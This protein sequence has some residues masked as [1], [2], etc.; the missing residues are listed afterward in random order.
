MKRIGVLLLVLLLCGSLFACAEL[1][2][3]QDAFFKSPES[4]MIGCTF[5]EVEAAFGPFSM[6]HI[7][8]DRPASYLFG[9]TN[10]A[11]HFD[12]P[13][14]QAAWAAQLPQGIGFIPGAVA[15]RSIQPADR[16]IGVSG[17]IRDFGIA[18]SDV[19]EISRY[20]SVLK[21]ASYET[22]DNTIYTL[23]SQDGAY[24]VFLYCTKGE[25]SFTANHQ[26]R[27]MAAGAEPQPVVEPVVSVQVTEFSLGGIAI[28]VGAVEAE[29]RGASNAHRTVTEQE[30]ADLV[31][32]CPD[33][34]KLVLDYCDIEGADQIGQLTELTD[35]Q[36]STCGMKDVSFVENLRNLT[37]LSICHN[38]LTDVSA[39]EDLQLTY[40][41]LGDNPKLGNRGVRSAAK[42]TTLKTLHL[43]EMNISSLSSLSSLRAL[44]ILDLSYN[45]KITEDELA[46]LTK[47]TY[48]RELDIN[49]T[50]VTDVSILFTAFPRLRTLEARKLKKLADPMPSYFSLSQ[51]TR[52]KTLELS[53]GDKEALDA[54]A[55][56]QYGMTAA[57]WFE[58]QGI[59]LK[60]K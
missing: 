50:G 45:A 28:P 9:K 30:L 53:K 41:N 26:I 35:L 20:M 27:V 60:Y 16:C 44:S 51:L 36:L 10:V 57:Q 19:A 7:S 40:L 18:E 1:Q 32:Y 4:A 14:A 58:T 25:V 13:D 21:P 33:L 3:A 59:E 42:V 22:D 49:S 23:T 12:A 11:F 6:V 34:K 47:Q 39:I 38:E 56:E 46:K 2:N 5:Q 43:Y 52:L 29:V 31:K 48:L 54:Y 8:E 37:W 17:R 55:T 24:D 15:L